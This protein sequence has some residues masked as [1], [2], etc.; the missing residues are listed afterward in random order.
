M[1]SCWT[2]FFGVL[3]MGCQIPEDK[4]LW[5]VRTGQQ[6]FFE[7]HI[8]QRINQKSDEQVVVQ[9]KIYRQLRNG[10]QSQHDGKELLGIPLVLRCSP[11][12]DFEEVLNWQDVQKQWLKQYQQE[13]LRLNEILR[14]D[15]LS[16]AMSKEKIGK[17]IQSKRKRLYTKEGVARELA[18]IMGLYKQK[19]PL[20]LKYQP[21]EDGE[22]RVYFI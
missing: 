18:R 8:L 1:R 17:L 5:E 7:Y 2:F 9:W 6:S 14:E 10:K 4:I 19:I 11:Q 15:P 21:E 3:L 20:E 16:Q 12:G 22:D 13:L